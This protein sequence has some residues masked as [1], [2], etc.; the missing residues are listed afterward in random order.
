MSTAELTAASITLDQWEIVSF[1][2]TG[3]DNVPTSFSYRIYRAEPG[4]SCSVVGEC[5]GTP[6]PAVTPT[7][8]DV[9]TPC[10]DVNTFNGIGCPSLDPGCPRT[11][12]VPQL[13]ANFGGF[14]ICKTP[15]FPPGAAGNKAEYYSGPNPA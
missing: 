12:T 5:P 13:K 2:G 15:P 4:M 1:G 3:A 14:D 7:P 6:D 11:Q 10:Y 9:P 8:A